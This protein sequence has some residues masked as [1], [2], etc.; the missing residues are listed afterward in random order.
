[1]D[2]VIDALSPIA[3]ERGVT[4]ERHIPPG[5]SV[6]CDRERVTQV[7]SN[8]IANAIKFTREKGAI[9]IRAARSD[10]DLLF[11]VADT[12]AGDRARGA[13]HVFERY[14][15]KDRG[16]G[17]G[18][19]LH[20]AKALVEAHGGRIWATSE[21]DRGSTFF[22]TLPQQRMPETVQRPEELRGR[23]P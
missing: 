17:T 7:L 3:R 10:S 8:L 9:T 19:G 18:L 11:A 14:F 23:A 15:T 12:G 5:A 16:R 6:R 2:E 20:I 13:A 1:M 21:L 22:F 4:I